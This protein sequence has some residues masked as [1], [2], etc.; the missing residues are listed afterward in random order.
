M[1][2]PTRN[3]LEK[4]LG[5][6]VEIILFDRTL[7][8]GILH[9]TGQEEF[10]NDPNLYIPQNRYF[11]VEEESIVKTLFRVSHVRCLNVIDRE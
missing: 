1:I 11:C 8:K 10:K 6:H 4:Y 9:K 2:R 3:E 5:K 7:I